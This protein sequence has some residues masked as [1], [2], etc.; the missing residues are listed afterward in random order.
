VGEL[1]TVELDF[2]GTLPYDDRVREAAML[3]R[4]FVVNR[5]GSA[6]SRALT[7]L[8]TEHLLDSSRLR[9]LLDR[10]RLRK[11]LARLEV[12]ESQLTEE[13]IICSVRCSYW[14]DC[15]YQNGGY[16]CGIRSL[17]LVVREK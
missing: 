17:E 7:R 9:A 16:P 4:P 2:W 14:G 15:E 10:K 6:A 12:P 13:P 1:L 3:Q 5:P 8:V 11:I